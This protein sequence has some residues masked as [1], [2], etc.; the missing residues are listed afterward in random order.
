MPGVTPLGPTSGTCSSD[1]VSQCSNMW[2]PSL[3]EACCNVHPASLRTHSHTILKKVNTWVEKTQK[4]IKFLFLIGLVHGNSL[5]RQE[6]ACDFISAVSELKLN[7]LWLV[8]SKIWFGVCTVLAVA[9]FSFTLPSLR[10]YRT[11][12]K[13]FPLKASSVLPWAVAICPRSRTLFQWMAPPK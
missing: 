7:V 12:V 2:H 9:S 11:D 13:L 10:F 3:T 5:D 4:R 6:R 8:D 1:T